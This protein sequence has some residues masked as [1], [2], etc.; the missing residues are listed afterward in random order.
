MMSLSNVSTSIYELIYTYTI[1]DVL[2]T[3]PQPMLNIT[4]I[5]SDVYLAGMPFDLRCSVTLSN[6][7]D[8]DIGVA[9]SWLRNGVNLNDTARIRTSQQQQPALM[10]DYE[11]LLRFDTLS[12][13]SDSGDYV[14]SAILYPTEIT[15][16][17]SNSTS[18]SSYYAIT[19]I[20][21][22]M[23]TFPV[24]SLHSNSYSTPNCII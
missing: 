12:S 18:A 15:D 24:P 13:T 20:G 17:I 9:V 16:Y 2:I 6:A 10:G 4:A 21:K 5:W 3:V 22:T 14:C 7:V 1:L 8:L 19:V 23:L 11:S